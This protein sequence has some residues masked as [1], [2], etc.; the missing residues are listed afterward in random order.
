MITLSIIIVNWNSKVWLKKCIDS[1]QSQTYRDYEIILVDNASSD[2]SLLFVKQNYPSIK[3]IANTEN[4]GFGVA[5]K[6]GITNAN[7]SH[8]LL[9]NVDTW[10]ET[11][12]LDRIMH[13]FNS[14]NYDLI[15]VKE[16][17][18]S[19]R[20]SHSSGSHLYTCDL[21]GYFSYINKNP[22]QHKL[23]Y[24]PGFCMLF[25][26]ILYQDTGGF[27]SAMF[28][29]YEDL[30]WCWRLHLFGKKIYLHDQVHIHH[31]EQ[32]TQKKK[33]TNA[34]KFLWRN[35]NLL[36]TVL[37]N[38]SAKTLIIILPLILLQ[39]L[40]EIIFLTLL[41]KPCLAYT[42]IQAWIINLSNIREIFQLRSQIQK[43]RQISDRQ[44]ISKMYW[45][46]GRL[47]HLLRDYRKLF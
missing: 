25:K 35:T 1:I 26:K 16:T 36:R 47:Q 45:G 27:D 9:L 28:M 32:G 5:N 18:Y 12:F 30:D 14:N 15:G 21:F 31:A 8:I 22:N 38:Y 46:S 33:V 13:F 2:D 44:I 7:G 11:N 34:Q 29:Y 43:N 6:I 37:K 17:S 41:L 3:I 39:N 20:Q 42:Y 19:D 23:F 4:Y 40:L 10:I 24:I